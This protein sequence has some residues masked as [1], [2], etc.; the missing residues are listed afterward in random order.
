[1]SDVKSYIKNIIDASGSKHKEPSNSPITIGGD[2]NIISNSHIHITPGKEHITESQASQLKYLVH[3]LARLECIHSSNP[4]FMPAIWESL[5]QRMNVT[6]Y[7]LIPHGHFSEAEK[8]L[9]DWRAR[10]MQDSKRAPQAVKD[11][12][13]VYRI[14]H[15]I[16]KHYNFYT[17]MRTF[18]LAKWQAES[19][20]DIDD[21]GLQSLLAFMRALEAQARSESTNCTN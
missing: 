1:M 21:A 12:S 8:F 9:M 17:E 10:V 16:A 4:V 7:K 18:M 5:K 15:A 19:M 3:E 13:R 20:R 14:C 6:S 11:R 2:L